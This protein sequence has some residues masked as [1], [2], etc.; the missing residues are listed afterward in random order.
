VPLFPEKK[1]NYFG[2]TLHH[3]NLARYTLE[4]ANYAM[5]PDSHLNFRLRGIP[6]DCRTKL[7][8]C[9]LVRRTLS[10]D[11]RTP[12]IVYSLSLNPSD[13]RSRVATLTFDKIPSLL[14]DRPE[15]QWAFYPQVPE[16]QD[17]DGDVNMDPIVFDMHFIGFTP[18]N[19]VE[20]D[21]ACHVE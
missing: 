6:L 17:E 12:V 16:S 5:P 13:P 9:D 19:S 7:G 14:P 8:V 20:D 3:P 2:I 18:L 10:I 15:K 1:E 4:T 11:Q 21:D